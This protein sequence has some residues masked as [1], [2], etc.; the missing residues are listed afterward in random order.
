MLPPPRTSRV[1][2]LVGA[3]L[4][5]VGTALRTAQHAIDAHAA[6]PR[7]TR[8][9]VRPKIAFHAPAEVVLCGSDVPVLEIGTA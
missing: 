4:F 3:L 7:R 5:G 6:S 2:V 9:F 8:Y 1:L